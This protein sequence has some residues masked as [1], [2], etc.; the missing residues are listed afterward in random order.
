MVPLKLI[1]LSCTPCLTCR[2]GH[3]GAN[4][5]AIQDVSMYLLV[6]CGVLH[7]SAYSAREGFGV[8]LA[9]QESQ[10]SSPVGSPYSTEKHN[11]AQFVDQGGGN[12]EGHI[13]AE[14][15]FQESLALSNKTSRTFR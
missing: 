7:V 5:V 11:F 3:D 1:S 9:L 8:R 6:F 14:A 2:L 15:P 13:G 4:E 12:G 10:P